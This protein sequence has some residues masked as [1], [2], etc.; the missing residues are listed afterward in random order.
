MK[1]SIENIYR[2]FGRFDKVVTLSFAPDSESFKE[3][4]DYMTGIFEYNREERENL[5]LKLLDE[6]SQ[7]QG[8]IK[9][10]EILNE[11]SDIQKSKLIQTGINTSEIIDIFHY[12][13]LFHF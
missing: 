8:F 6:N 3:Y 5:E 4:P 1:Y 7:S 10:K 12:E 13:V 2:D 9:F 11:V